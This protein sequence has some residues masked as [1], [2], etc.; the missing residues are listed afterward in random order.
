[1]KPTIT[2]TCDNCG[3]EFLKNKATYQ[4]AVR[5]NQTSFCCSRTCARRGSP[6]S[7]YIRKAK[8]RGKCGNISEEYLSDLWQEQDGRCSYT[9]IQLVLHGAVNDLRTLAS[10]DRIDS[11]LPY[12]MGNVQFV[13]GCINMAKNIMPNDDMIAFIKAIK[14]RRNT[15]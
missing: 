3:C 14:E 2:L 11:S 8:Y 7:Y 1:M 9:G 13:S 5:N 12:E 6:F 15:I 4:Q 10:L